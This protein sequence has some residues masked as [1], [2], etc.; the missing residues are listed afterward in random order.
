MRSWFA[1]ISLVLAVI[2]I[3]AHNLA[4]HDHDHHSFAVR[5]SSDHDEDHEKRGLF[6]LNLIDHCFTSQTS[7]DLHHTIPAI[8]V[9]PVS[10]PVALPEVICYPVLK[11]S[12]QLKHEFPPPLQVGSSSISFRGP[13][14]LSA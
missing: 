8:I 1:K 9:A 3:T 13:P 4:F 10:A 5:H 2:I 12:Y 14:I 7:A 6:A 11:T